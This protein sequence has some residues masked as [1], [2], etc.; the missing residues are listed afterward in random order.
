M[1][2]PDWAVNGSLWEN[3]QT[4]VRQK[5]GISSGDR[6]EELVEARYLVIGGSIN[7]TAFIK[8]EEETMQKAQVWVKPSSKKKRK[9]YWKTIRGTA[10]VSHEK[11]MR[12]RPEPEK[13]T[14]TVKDIPLWAMDRSKWM[15][16]ANVVVRAQQKDPKRF[17]GHEYAMAAYIYKRMGGRK[18]N[19]PEGGKRKAPPS[20]QEKVASFPEVL[21]DMATGELLVKAEQHFRSEEQRKFMWAKHPDIAE[22]WAHGERA[23]SGEGPVR[24]PP[25]RG[26]GVHSVAAGATSETRAGR[27]KLRAEKKATEESKRKAA[28]F[29]ED[30]PL[31]RAGRHIQ[32][33]LRKAQAVAAPAVPAPKKPPATTSNPA[34][35]KMNGNGAVPKP[36]LPVQKPMPGFSPDGDGK[37][38]AQIGEVRTWQSGEMKKVG[39]NKWEP[40]AQNGKTPKAEQDGQEPP[41]NGKEPE[42]QKPQATPEQKKSVATTV[43]R[44]ASKVAGAL[45]DKMKDIVTDRFLQNLV[46][47]GKE[48]GSLAGEVKR[49]VAGKKGEKEETPSMNLPEKKEEGTVTNKP[50]EEGEEATKEPTQEPPKEEGREEKEK[51]TAEP[52]P[53]EKREETESEKHVKEEEPSPEEVKRKAGIEKKVRKHVQNLAAGLYEKQ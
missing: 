24:K 9:G 47:P 48:G 38:K 50:K 36:G 25:V 8:S 52:P 14:N 28:S 45:L 17:K 44:I 51:Q 21:I 35:P 29:E 4:D 23:G 43:T 33:V 42:A 3:A 34:M 49:A 46:P 12:P 18:A 11:E 27:K 2:K 22:K 53:E 39:E 26:P 10:K 37:H 20:V 32:F 30:K 5:Y 1:R 13:K 15:Q 19:P 40:A 16:A 31:G 41:K 7:R 6:F